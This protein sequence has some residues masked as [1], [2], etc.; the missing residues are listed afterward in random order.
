MG[1]TQE[2]TAAETAHAKPKPKPAAADAS[3]SER[4]AQE[5]KESLKA[6]TAGTAAGIFSKIIEYPFDTV[7]GMRPVLC[8][9]V[10][11]CFDR[12]SPDRQSVFCRCQ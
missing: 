5:F 4:A 12:T 8:V 11:V 1:E 10:G 3:L 6:W 9:C 2:M 7:K